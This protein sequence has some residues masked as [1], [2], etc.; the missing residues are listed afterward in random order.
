VIIHS[1]YSV[2]ALLLAGADE[3]I[4]NEDGLTPAQ[5]AVMRGRHTVLPMLDVSSKW[6]LLVRSHRLRRRAAVRVMM[7]LARWKVQTRSIWTRAKMTVHN[8]IICAVFKYRHNYQR[9]YSPRRYKR[10]QTR[11]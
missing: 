11:N 7:S 4:I 10:V 2:G 8:I 5:W 1:S 9:M 3:T 6:K